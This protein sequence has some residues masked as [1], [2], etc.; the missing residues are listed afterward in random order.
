MTS[1]YSG[2]SLDGNCINP[3]YLASMRKRAYS[4]QP[5]IF[6]FA[7]RH[8]QT[9]GGRTRARA[10]VYVHVRAVC[11]CRESIN[12]I[13]VNA[14]INFGD[15]LDGMYNIACARSVSENVGLLLKNSY[16]VSDNVDLVLFLGNAFVP[17]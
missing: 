12:D 16:V 9:C 6:S 5:G 1:Q 13:T 4:L 3:E 2:H 8:C 10:C 15:T 17:R 11:M 14:K 7:G